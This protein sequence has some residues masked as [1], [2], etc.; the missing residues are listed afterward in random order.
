VGAVDS[1]ID[2]VGTAVALELLGI[3]EVTAGPVALGVGTVHGAHGVLPNPAPAVTRLLE[4][5]PVRGVDVPGE[6]TTPTGAALL[7]AL[8]SR[9]GPVPAMTVTASG[10]GAGSRN[11][12]GRPNL[13][14]VVVGEADPATVEPGPPDDGRWETVCCLETNLDD[15]TAEALGHLLARL[16]EEGAVDAWCTPVTMKK[17][18]PGVVLSVLCPLDDAAAVRQ[19]VARETGTL[20]I[21]L[22]PQQ[23]WVAHRHTVEVRLEGIPIRVKVGPHGHKAE[24]DD[25]AAAARRLGLP[26]RDVARRAAELAGE[27]GSG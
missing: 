16:L 23:R 26:W 13:L 14:Q 2:I 22:R 1:I 19:L 4:G 10:Y 21:R 24:F 11:P 27:G 15:V 5:V 12:P 8:C 3:D 20:G 6:L 17:A 18:R 9:F 25:V 7:A